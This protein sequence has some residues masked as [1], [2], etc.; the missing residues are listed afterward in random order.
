MFILSYAMILFI[1]HKEIYFFECLYFSKYDIRMYLYVFWLRKGKSVKCVGNWWGVWGSSKMRKAA[2]RERECDAS[3]VR[4]HLHYSFSCFW[5]HFCL[6]VSFFICRNLTL[7][8][9]QNHVFIRDGYF[10]PIR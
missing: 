10:S 3:C 5:Q 9:I 8:L 6:I 4:T 7:S 1:F 2:Y